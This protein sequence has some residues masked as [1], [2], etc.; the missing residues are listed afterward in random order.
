MERIKNDSSYTRRGGRFF[1]PNKALDECFEPEY[2]EPDLSTQ[3]ANEESDEIL[4]D[5]QK[6]CMSEIAP[7]LSIVHSDPWHLLNNSIV[8]IAPRSKN[9]YAITGALYTTT[10]EETSVDRRLIEKSDWCSDTVLQG[11][12]QRELE[13][14]LDDGCFCSAKF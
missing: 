5:G 7:I 10:R 3:S 13:W 2:L 6:F 12:T 1:E 4:D 8:E 14:I 11:S 9:L